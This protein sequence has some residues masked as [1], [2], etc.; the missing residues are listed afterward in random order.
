MNLTVGTPGFESET[1]LEI[2]RFNPFR[3]SG[4]GLTNVE[5]NGSHER[6]R[7]APGH[8]SRLHTIVEPHLFVDER[9][10]KMH[11]RCARGQLIRDRRKGKVMRS[12]KADRSVIQEAAKYAGGADQSI[13]RVGSLQ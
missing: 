12:H 11:I 6:E 1:W 8:W 3:V 10:L 2:Q 4:L 7:V 13:M 5:S 9:I